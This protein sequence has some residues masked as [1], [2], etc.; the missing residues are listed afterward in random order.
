MQNRKSKKSYYFKNCNL[1]KSLIKKQLKIKI[2]RVQ[3]ML[4]KNNKNFKIQKFKL[5]NKKKNKLSE[6]K[7]FIKLLLVLKLTIKFQNFLLL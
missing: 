1:L 7:F 5:K 4:M 3:K 2:L 6:V